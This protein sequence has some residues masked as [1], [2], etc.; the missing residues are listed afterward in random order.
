MVERNNWELFYACAFQDY[1]KIKSALDKDADPNWVFT[2]KKALP[3]TSGRITNK[4]R[5]MAAEATSARIG[6]PW[7]LPRGRD[8]LL[9]SKQRRAIDNLHQMA[10]IDPPVGVHGSNV[11]ALQHNEPILTPAPSSSTTFIERIEYRFNGENEGEPGRRERWKY[12][13]TGIVGAPPGE[14]RETPITLSWKATVEDGDTALLVFMRSIV[15]GAYP[16]GTFPPVPV[17]QPF[18]DGAPRWGARR[19]SEFQGQDG[20]L[21]HRSASGCLKLLLESGATGFKQNITG[22]SVC[23][24]RDG[25]ELQGGNKMLARICKMTK[26]YKT[27][28]RF[29]PRFD[30]SPRF[31]GARVGSVFRQGAK[32]LGY[33]RDAHEGLKGKGDRLVDAPPAEWGTAKYMEKSIG[34][35][36]GVDDIEAAIIGAS[37][38]SRDKMVPGGGEAE[39][40][41]RVVRTIHPSAASEKVFTG[42]TRE[43]ILGMLKG[44]RK[45][46]RRRR[47]A[48]RKR[49]VRRRTRRKR[50]SKRRRKKSRKSRRR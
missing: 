46:T 27:M 33:Y 36:C 8:S 39:L 7:G 45:K 26:M 3:Y 13:W 40:T 35:I 23:G 6:E 5:K 47:R 17:P 41:G 19:A 50:R 9:D 37:G 38:R 44:G 29:L 43:I 11:K 28:V 49:A 12:W 18:N 25:E 20:D 32:G 31:T 1:D 14:G 10:T 2:Y 42:D 24:T 34:V 16:F 15:G 48:R 21:R 22:E 4:V 30:A